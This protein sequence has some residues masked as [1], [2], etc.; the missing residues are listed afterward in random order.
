M[1][2]KFLRNNFSIYKWE[3]SFKKPFKVSLARKRPK[4]CYLVWMPQARAQYFTNSNWERPKAKSQ[5]LDS[6][7]SASSFRILSLTCGTWVVR[8]FL[9]QCGSTTIST[10]MPSYTW[11]TLR[12]KT[13]CILPKTNF[14]ECLQRKSLKTLF[15]WYSP[16]NRILP[17]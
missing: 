1:C 14:I 16:I 9:D 7:W 17:C 11:L 4:S 2:L 8:I 15:Y 5:L 6:T 13:D 10:A 3:I 12:T